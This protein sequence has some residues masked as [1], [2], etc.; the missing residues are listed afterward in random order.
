MN[1]LDTHHAGPVYC[2]E[3]SAKILSVMGKGY[4]KRE[5]GVIDVKPLY[6]HLNMKPL[7]MDTPE[8]VTTEFGEVRVTLLNANHCPGSVM[9]LFQGS[10]GT[11]LYTGDLR[12]E[13]YFLDGLA[14]CPALTNGDGLI[15]IDKMYLDTTFCHPH[16]DE[17]LTKMES[18]K[19]LIAVMSQYP[20]DQHFNMNMTILGYEPI[21]MMVAM[22]FSTQVYIDPS[23]YI[24]YEQFEKCTPTASTTP[25]A[26]ITNYLTLD[27]TST[28]FHAC[29]AKSG[30]QICVEKYQQ[31]RSVWV[32]ASSAGW[33]EW[34]K[35]RKV[36]THQDPNHP[37][38]EVMRVGV[39]RSR[40]SGDLK[41]LYS[42]H[43]SFSELRSMVGMFRPREVFSCVMDKTAVRGG[44][45]AQYFRDLLDQRSI[46]SVKSLTSEVEKEEE[47]HP[48]ALLQR[49][50]TKM[51]ELLRE[52]N[53][54]AAPEVDDLSSTQ[55]EVEFLGVGELIGAEVNDDVSTED[56]DVDATGPVRPYVELKLSYS[57]DSGSEREATPNLL[58]TEPASVSL[59]PASPVPFLDSDTTD[60]GGVAWSGSPP[61][62]D[63]S[64]L[65]DSTIVR[66]A[67]NRTADN[68]SNDFIDLTALDNRPSGPQRTVSTPTP[69]VTGGRMV[70]TRRVHSAMASAGGNS[71]DVI[72]V[73]E[74]VPASRNGRSDEGNRM[75]SRNSGTKT[76]SKAPRPPKRSISAATSASASTPTT[77]V[78]STPIEC[79]DLTAEDD[80]VSPT[81][82]SS[83][84]RPSSARKTR[85]DV[86][87][88]S[89]TV[90]KGR[91][92]KS[93]T[94]PHEEDWLVRLRKKRSGL[95]DG[96][97][98]R[99]K[100]PSSLRI[101]DFD[102]YGRDYGPDLIVADE[103]GGDGGGGIWKI[104][105][106]G[107][108][109]TAVTPVLEDARGHLDLVASSVDRGLVD[110]YRD[111]VLAG[112]R[113]DLACC[114]DL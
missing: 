101:E 20:A 54:E 103:G 36:P 102:V 72:E 4:K 84:C 105:T 67:N 13:S 33:R 80:G 63:R 61:P 79:I 38:H 52:I 95:S 51:E 83:N 35:G 22:A 97:T 114:Y 34:S 16:Y 78:S 14:Q 70:A 73:F 88:S 82:C 15:S 9:I 7:P 104:P 21:Y 41:V 5:N 99:E 100:E 12:A 32:N 6:K 64:K 57:D 109:G 94:G 37:G 10:N 91:K 92:R 53:W 44:G 86:F 27:P 74:D 69:T 98:D 1:G 110:V 49:Q 50:S 25:D 68:I 93:D 48:P 85:S 112:Q 87:E 28:R 11:V 62:A 81:Q 90:R 56:E 89:S 43:S 30:C 65:V 29:G 31:R 77:P 2:S 17:F 55:V 111:R 39:A 66:Q 23:R 3:I 8:I 75:I 113:L 40:R 47:A 18:V 76:P 108:E 106:V 107:P 60:D 42:M 59:A 24:Y 19:S 58:A 45:F 46:D 26:A 71:L 96:G